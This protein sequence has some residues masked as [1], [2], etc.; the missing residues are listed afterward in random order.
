M[1]TTAILV[2]A[3]RGTRAGGDIPKQW[4]RL[5]DRSVADHAITTFADHP[6][7]AHVVL[8]VH[9]DDATSDHWN[10][11]EGLIVV[12]GG[13][14]RSASVQNGLDAAPDGTKTVL[15]HD[16]ARPHIRHGVIDDVL[17][18]L[19]T[20][21]AAAPALAVTDT[22]WRGDGGK[23]DGTVPRDDLY[24]AQTPQGF[25]LDALLDAYAAHPEA[26]DD[27]TIAR[28]AGLDVAIVNGDEDN[29]K[30]TGPDDHA[31]A[32]RILGTQ[33]DV[34]LG[35]GY[36]VHRFGDGDHVW[37][38]GVKVPHTR[39]LQGH[40]D[41]DVGM[42]AV[43][44]A[45]YGAL[46]QGDIGQHFPPSDPQWKGADSRIFLEHAVTLARSQGFEISNI[47]C[48]LVC[49]Y[50]K[51]GPHQSVMKDKMAEIMGLDP[52]R[53]SVKATTSERLGFTGRSEGI[54]SLATAV[55]IKQ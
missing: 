35:N 20:H 28:L 2:A 44:D 29:M 10:D 16:A 48:T 50:P 42:H 49:E 51:I 14:T 47:D 39:S 6:D 8:V 46:G 36:D 41:A 17:S 11:F 18:A 55:L 7:I 37:L 54:A 30:I 27:V 15:I 45:I 1:T 19:K 4:Q 9:P 52:S 13:V 21:P 33:M 24:R 38:C 12:H 22:L 32:A 26:T 23:V 40:S 34:R 43:T 3:G 31:R 25:H 5:G 53:I